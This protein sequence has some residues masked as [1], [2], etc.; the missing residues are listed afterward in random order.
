MISFSLRP[1]SVMTV[2]RRAM[3]RRAP[4]SW[5]WSVNWRV[6]SWKRRSY[7]WRRCVAS[8]EPSSLSDSSRTLTM[9]IATTHSLAN[10]ELDADRQLVAGQAHGLGRLVLRHAGHLEEDPAGLD[11]R[12]PVVGR[13]LARAH[14]DLGRLLGDR[15]V[16][17]DADPDLAAALDVTGHRASSSLYLARR[18]PRRFLGHQR[19]LAERDR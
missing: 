16:G 6:A 12:D 8:S 17:E 2:S 19:E 13:A 1:R 15:L 11:D 3:V 5:L 14:S 7:R 10:Q 9:S 4:V 18:D